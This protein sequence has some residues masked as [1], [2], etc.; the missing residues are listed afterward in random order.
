VRQGFIPRSPAAVIKRP[1]ARATEMQS[2]TVDE[3]AAFLDHVADDRL[4]AA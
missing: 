3:A 1:R 2:W 4:Y